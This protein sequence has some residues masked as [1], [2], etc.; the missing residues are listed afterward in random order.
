MNLILLN[1][2]GSDAALASVQEALAVS[3]R[4][5]HRKGDVRRSGKLWERAG[6]SAAVV[7]AANPKELE[8]GLQ[9]FLELCQ[10]RNVSFSGPEIEAELSVGVTVGDSQQF[11][12]SIDFS[13]SVLTALAACG[14]ALS[15][16]AYPTSD[17]ENAGDAT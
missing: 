12:V 11:V 2:Q 16:T 4:S 10:S 14:V 6:F 9:R 17:E 5:A 15:F 7:D 3:P 8:E 13:P 1:V